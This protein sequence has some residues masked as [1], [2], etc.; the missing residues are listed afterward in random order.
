ML[1]IPSCVRSSEE[2]G[3][4]LSLIAVFVDA[5]VIME[6][7]INRLAQ[8]KRCLMSMFKMRDLGEAKTLL[9]IRVRRDEHA[10]YLDQELYIN[11]LLSKFQMENCKTVSTPMEVGATLMPAGPGE[12]RC[13]LPYQE[14]LGCLIYLSITTRPDLCNAVSRLAQ[15]ASCYNDQLFKAAKRVLRYLK[16]NASHCLLFPANRNVGQFPELIGC[17][18]ADWGSN[19]SDRKSFTGYVVKLG[20]CP[21]SFSSSKQKCNSQST[22]ESEYVAYSEIAK[23]VLFL[24]SLLSELVGQ[25]GT[26]R[27]YSDSQSA[28]AL[29]NSE[30]YRVKKVRSFKS[31]TITDYR[32]LPCIAALLIKNSQQ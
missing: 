2:Q 14:L 29:P 16:S 18:D 3:D 5:L 20:E 17:V 24:R 19:L 13:D 15:F 11:S 25:I 12:E 22:A 8:I 10:I 9:G 6:K 4:D 1:Y 26:T 27:I 32:Y 28:I 30:H 23:E 31:C 7:N 21:V